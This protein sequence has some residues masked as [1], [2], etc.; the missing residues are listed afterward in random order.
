MLFIRS[1]CSGH[2]TYHILPD[3]IF[4]GSR[5][6]FDIRPKLLKSR[7]SKNNLYCDICGQTGAE[8]DESIRYS[9]HIIQS[10]SLKAEEQYWACRRKSVRLR[11]L[12]GWTA[13][14][15]SFF[16]WWTSENR[17][18]IFL[19]YSKGRLFIRYIYRGIKNHCIY[20]FVLISSRP[21][22]TDYV[23]GT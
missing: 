2:Y 9:K 7:K 10:H 4:D 19:L 8:L 18:L 23:Q 12:Q 15:S 6:T 16:T 1:Y 20:I 22:A 13:V 11:A 3:L 5:K 14:R 17:L 21:Y